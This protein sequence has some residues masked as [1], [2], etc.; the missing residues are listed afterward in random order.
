MRKFDLKLRLQ[1]VLPILISLCLHG[2]AQGAS[3]DCDKTLT[4]VEKIICSNPELSALDEE[5]DKVYREALQK[6]PD[7]SALKLQQLGWLK[8]RNS[9]KDTSCL[10]VQYLLRN[11]ELSRIISLVPLAS[12]Q[13]SHY[14][15]KESD[16]LLVM[17]DVVR[18]QEFSPSLA[19]QPELA[20]CA[21]FL[22]DFV[23]GRDIEVVE[24]N[25]SSNDEN[26]PRFAKLNRCLNHVRPLGT[27]SSDFYN[28][29]T[30]GGPPYRFYRIDVDGSSENVQ[31]DV[32]YSENGYQGETGYFWID[33][34]ECVVRGGTNV[35]PRFRPAKFDSPQ[36]IYRLNIFVLYQ[37]MPMSVELRPLSWTPEPTRYRFEMMRFEK[38]KQPHICA[39]R[40]N[41]DQEKTP[42]IQNSTSESGN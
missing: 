10:N 34:E 4:K 25:F 16:K 41:L 30:I 28:V 9:C 23:A 39:W 20:F 29:A 17:Q 13:E 12:G 22:K 6:A 21:G 24:P 35:Q 27:S 19:Y 8:E 11:G 26:D 5:L 18:R 38:N 2:Q 7:Q 3:F 42:G 14:F 31:K 36:N 15:K 33:S 40:P 1:W 37:G 32:L